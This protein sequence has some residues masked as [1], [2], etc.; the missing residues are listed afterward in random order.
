MAIFSLLWVFA[1]RP[2]NKQRNP[3]QGGRNEMLLN[4][5]SQNR[6]RRSLLVINILNVISLSIL[7][8]LIFICL[9]HGQSLFKLRNS[10][11]NL[12]FFLLLDKIVYFSFSL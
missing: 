4:I 9:G 6:F 7:I 11:S 3:T 8:I 5:L 12:L 1:Y 2:R 10:M